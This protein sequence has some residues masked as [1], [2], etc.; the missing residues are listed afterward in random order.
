MSISP[1][2]RWHIVTGKGGVG[3]TTTAV[4][5]AQAL[6]RG[7]RRVL[8]AEVEQRGGLAP[9]LG[10]PVVGHAEQ[11]VW[12]ASADGQ[13]YAIDVNADKALFDYLELNYKLGR[14]VRA[15]RRVGA[16]DF[17]TGI[18]PG[19]KDLLL[20]G[21]IS[22][23]V[24]RKASDDSAKSHRGAATAFH[25]DAVVLDAPPTGRI[26]KFLNVAG[27]VAD[28]VKVGPIKKQ[29][30]GIME[31]LRSNDAVVHVVTLLEELPIQETR[32]ALAELAAL[33]VHIGLIVAN[34]VAQTDLTR[35]RIT[36]AELSRGLAAAGLPT[37]SGTIRGL[38][39][40]GRAAQLRLR[41]QEK[42]RRSLD[43]L[44][45]PVVDLPT[46]SPRVTPQNLSVLRDKLRNQLPTIE[47][48]GARTSV[49]D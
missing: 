1:Y 21:K 40:D 48:A 2:P 20:L 41:F 17:A 35:L 44:P 45:Y 30:E 6:A 12:G 47:D 10:S 19:L 8:V 26:G 43:K 18:A 36:R 38:A 29:S 7:G 11:P 23:A 42:L 4:A 16:V 34:N 39:E 5:L 37:D 25:Y 31:L 3:K 13:V 27:A 32:E 33:N 28:L 24:K 14:T 9:V 15:L 22:E 46:L 49:A